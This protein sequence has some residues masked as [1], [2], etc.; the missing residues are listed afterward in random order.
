MPHVGQS[1]ESMPSHYTYHLLSITVA[2]IIICSCI[3]TRSDQSSHQKYKASWIHKDQHLPVCLSCP[4]STVVLPCW[5]W[6]A[7]PRNVLC[8]KVCDA[9]LLCVEVQE[10]KTLP[11]PLSCHGMPSNYC[12]MQTK[13]LPR[14]AEM[15]DPTLN[16]N[17]SGSGMCST[18]LN[19]CLV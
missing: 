16:S 11:R 18:T 2:F 3:L 17:C 15:R 13:S 7:I 1:Q 14:S 10:K 4:S 12:T 9:F 8:P 6:L 19:P 5:C